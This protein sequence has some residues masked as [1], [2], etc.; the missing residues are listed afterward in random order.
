MDYITIYVKPVF[1]QDQISIYTQGLLVPYTDHFEY[2][3]SYHYK[4]CMG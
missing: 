3:T 2:L 4:K 1:I